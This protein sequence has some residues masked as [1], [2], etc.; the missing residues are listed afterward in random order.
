MTSRDETL[1]GLLREV[2]DLHHRYYRLTDGE[3]PDWA[4]FYAH[5]LVHHSELADVLGRAP[6]RSEVTA[7]LVQAARDHS[8]DPDW[9]TAYAQAFLR[10]YA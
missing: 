6:V 8:A 9:A 3:D 5:W 10:H 7:L 2:A 4:S 1:A